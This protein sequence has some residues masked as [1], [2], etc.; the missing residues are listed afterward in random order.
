MFTQLINFR[1]DIQNL[2]QENE[3]FERQLSSSEGGAPSNNRE[4]VSSDG[5]VVANVSSC[6][7]DGAKNSS[8]SNRKENI[9]DPKSS[10]D[11]DPDGRF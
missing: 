2:R 11:S 5:G 8:W 7:I 9:I 6:H 10:E 1:R 3:L 4:S